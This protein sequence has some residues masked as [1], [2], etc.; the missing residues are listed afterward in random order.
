MTSWPH[1]LSPE[2]KSHLEGMLQEAEKT[3]AV[4]RKKA[5]L[6]TVEELELKTLLA[7]EC[8]SPSDHEGTACSEENEACVLAQNVRASLTMTRYDFARLLDAE[9]DM[10][11]D[12]GWLND[13]IVNFY[14][15]L[16]RDGGLAGTRRR[17]CFIQFWASNRVHATKGTNRQ[18]AINTIFARMHNAA[19]RAP[20]AD[21]FPPPCV[22]RTDAVAFTI[23]NGVH[24]NTAVIDVGKRMVGRYDS[25]GWNGGDSHSV[26]VRRTEISLEALAAEQQ[27]AFDPQADLHQLAS[28]KPK[29][30]ILFTG[31][32]G[33]GNDCGVFSLATLDWLTD[34]LA[35]YPP[36]PATKGDE[37]FVHQKDMPNLR[38]RFALEMLKGQ[39][40]RT[41][42]NP[43]RHPAPES[44]A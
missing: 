24:W 31:E 30:H 32:Q 5:P 42:L 7:G 19:M 2:A 27:E 3:Q 8:L 22:Q 40:L 21:K 20:G 43:P 37:A 17:F 10:T 1:N 33:N 13:N 39:L 26:I 6:T 38:R 44:S 11:R 4:Q 18:E 34:D 28:Y 41:T 12:T 14:M 35:P 9:G 23:N 15:T 25:S 29:K 16:L 36:P